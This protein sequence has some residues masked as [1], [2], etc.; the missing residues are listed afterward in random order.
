MWLLTDACKFGQQ[1]LEKMG[2]KPGLGLGA[3][4]QGITEQIKVAYKNDKTC[5][6][7]SQVYAC[8]SNICWCIIKT[9]FFLVNEMIVYF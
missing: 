4:E 5:K 8:G 2:W 6:C 9:F 7:V 3:K 1:M